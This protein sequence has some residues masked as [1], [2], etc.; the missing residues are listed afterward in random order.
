MPPAFGVSPDD[1]YL[2]LDELLTFCASALDLIPL[3]PETADLEGA[4]A[5]RYITAGLP[6]ID[7]CPAMWA[8]AGVLLPAPTSPAVAALDAGHRSGAYQRVNLPTLNVLVMRCTPAFSL[9]EGAVTLP[10]SDELAENA[11][12]VYADGWAIWKEVS[13]A[14]KAGL[15]FSRCS[16]A[17]LDSGTPQDPSGGCAGWLFTVRIN[18]PGYPALP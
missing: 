4:P 14:I 13:R 5:L 12:Q 9:E 1:L 3:Y 2:A 18:L 15:L 10:T 16:E 7:C 11:R 17:Y 6:A 8:Y